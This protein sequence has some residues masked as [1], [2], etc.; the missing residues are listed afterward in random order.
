MVFYQMR[1]AFVGGSEHELVAVDPLQFAL[2]ASCS[3]AVP[4]GPQ[5]S[6]SSCAAYAKLDVDHL[7]RLAKLRR[8]RPQKFHRPRGRCRFRFH[9]RVSRLP[10]SGPTSRVSSQSSVACVRCRRA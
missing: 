1:E 4:W 8:P 10:L 3:H 7:R 2:D 6:L 5:F 9:P